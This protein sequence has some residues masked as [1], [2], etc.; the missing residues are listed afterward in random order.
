MYQIYNHV[1]GS[2]VASDVIHREMSLLKASGK[3]VVVSMGNYAASG[4]WAFGI[5]RPRV[6]L[7]RQQAPPL[8][9]WAA[10]PPA[11]GALCLCGLFAIVAGCIELNI[12]PKSWLS[13]QVLADTG[14]LI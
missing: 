2:A 6:C 4:G 7:L 1:G 3:P 13:I 10:L 5:V 11:T 8:S 9:A 14:I 12:D